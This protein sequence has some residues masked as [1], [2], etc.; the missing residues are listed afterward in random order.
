MLTYRSEGENVV[1][2]W[3]LREALLDDVLLGKRIHE[4]VMSP[5]Q[6]RA[7]IDL[8]KAGRGFLSRVNAKRRYVEA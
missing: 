6:D 2:N 3:P 8:Q 5:I 1:P 4:N 7:A